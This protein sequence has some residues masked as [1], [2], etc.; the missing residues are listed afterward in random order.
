MRVLRR[1]IAAV[2]AAVVMAAVL[3]VPAG[4]T[5]EATGEWRCE[6]GTD[7]F[8][9]RYTLLIQP[10]GDVDTRIYGTGPDLYRSISG[11][12]NEGY[13]R[14]WWERHYGDEWLERYGEHWK[15]RL[16]YRW[17]LGLPRCHAK[18][19]RY[20]ETP[21]ERTAREAQEAREARESALSQASAAQPAAPVNPDDAWGAGTWCERAPG[22]SGCQ[23]DEA[24]G[25]STPKNS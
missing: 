23:Y 8:G 22:H 14:G 10:D 12:G 19:D 24:T 16:H 11:D 5:K 1:S 7:R 17:G 9:S 2:L 21:A 4:A 6:T 13:Y 25:R 15:S 20:N 18:A 3:A